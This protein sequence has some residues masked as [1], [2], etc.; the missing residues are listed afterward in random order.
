MS[1]MEGKVC[2]V[3]GAADGIGREAAI[4]F[5]AEGASLV[6][7]DINEEKLAITRDLVGDDA[8]TV[9]TDVAD[10]NACQLMVDTAVEAFG[11][12]DVLLNNAGI[13]GARARTADVSTEEWNRVIAVNQTGVF[14]CSRA[15]IP[16]MQAGGGGVIINI[17]SVDGQ[18]GMGSLSHYVSSKHAVIGL[19][20]TIALEYGG[21]NIRAVAVAPGFIDT[22]MT[23]GALKPEERDLLNA[24]TP[25]GRAARPD[26]V[27]KL[28]MWLASDNASY[29]TGTCHN[30]DGGLLSG[31]NMPV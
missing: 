16:V 5:A 10:E 13:P 22:T 17:A 21:D 1:S 15:A 4:G 25:L 27:A 12:V 7:A 18:I 14:F 20:K 19:T 26:E 9:L 11:R 28:V 3:T 6:L 23:Q 24:L 2:L 30:V 29:V 8:I 31:F